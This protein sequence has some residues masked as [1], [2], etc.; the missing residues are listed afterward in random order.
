MRQNRFVAPRGRRGWAPGDG[1]WSPVVG[2]LV[3]C[4]E[5]RVHQFGMALTF[6]SP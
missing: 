1:G 5:Q 3:H 4:V 2:Y 6:H